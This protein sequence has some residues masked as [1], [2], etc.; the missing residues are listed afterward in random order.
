MQ[1]AADATGTQLLIPVLTLRKPLVLYNSLMHH[2]PDGVWASL[3]DSA[4][5]TDIIMMIFAKQ[6][7]AN[8]LISYVLSV[9]LHSSPA[10]ISLFRLV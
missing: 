4:F 1:F 3:C 9:V 7:T 5:I 8:L 2:C 6:F 10:P